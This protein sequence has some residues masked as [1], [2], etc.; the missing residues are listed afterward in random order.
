MPTIIKKDKEHNKM[1]VENHGQ[2]EL[3][4]YEESFSTWVRNSMYPE[5]YDYE[6][7]SKLYDSL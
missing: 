7:A 3:Y 5:L 6:R 2:F 4:Y 1:L